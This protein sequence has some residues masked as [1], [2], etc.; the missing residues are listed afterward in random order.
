MLLRGRPHP[1]VRRSI[2]HPSVPAPFRTHGGRCHKFLMASGLRRTAGFVAN[3][4]IDGFVYAGWWDAPTDSGTLVAG[5]SGD[6]LESARIRWRTHGARTKPQARGQKR[7]GSYN[8]QLPLAQ[9][10]GSCCF[11]T[12]SAMPKMKTHKASRKRFKVS[13]TGKLKRSQAGKKHL[14]SPKSGKQSANCVAESPKS[15]WWR[16]VHRGDGGQLISNCGF[17][18]AD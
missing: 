17:Q 7:F 13:A 8:T 3:R 5:T 4:P 14:N 18:I 1:H 9:T 15:A 10:E 11:F 6:A 12:E 16:K 2:L